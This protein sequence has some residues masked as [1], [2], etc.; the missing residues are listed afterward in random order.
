MAKG[1]FTA[2]LC[3]DWRQLR[4]QERTL[5]KLIVAAK[6]SI[7]TSQMCDLDGIFRLFDAIQDAGIESGEFSE[8]QV[9]GR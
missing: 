5:R 2:T 1:E 9:Y 7:T 3:I 8:K 6:S 4:K